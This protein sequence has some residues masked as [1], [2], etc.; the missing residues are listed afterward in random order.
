MLAQAGNVARNGVLGHFSRLIH[1]PPVGYA[2]RQRRDERGVAT[3]RFGPEHDVVAVS[4]LGHGTDTIVLQRAGQTQAAEGRGAREKKRVLFPI[5][6]APFEAI[7]DW[8]LFDADEGK[9]LAVEIRVP[10]QKPQPQRLKPHSRQC[11]YRSG[12][13]LRHPKSNAK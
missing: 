2:T 10:E 3:L 9:D 5:G 6:L 11:R 13:P 8:E 1:R 12:E 4:G 7:R